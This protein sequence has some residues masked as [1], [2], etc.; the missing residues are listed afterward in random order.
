MKGKRIAITI[1]IFFLVATMLP[2]TTFAQ[3]EVPYGP[4][5]DTITMQGEPEESKVVDMLKNND[6]DVHL[7]DIADPDLLP[8]IQAAPNLKYSTVLG[9]YYDLTLNPAVF[10]TAGFNPFS[11][12]KVREAMN[13]L[14]D[15]NYIVDEISKGLAVP[16]WVPTSNGIPDYGRLAPTIKV[17]EAK[18]SYDFEKAR[19][20]FTTELEKMGAKFIGGRWYYNDE[21]IEIKF[22]IRNDDIQRW[23]IGDY[24]ANQMEKL[25]FQTDRRYGKSAELSPIWA[26][27]I[28]STGQFHIYT[29]GWIATA[30]DRDAGDDFA[31]FYTK[32]SLMAIYGYTLW[33]YKENDPE[34]YD[35]AD[36]L[37][38]GDWTSWEE[39]NQLWRRALVL[40]MEDSNHVWLVNTA[41]P[42]PMNEN[43][44]VATDLLAGFSNDLWARTIRWEDQIG[45][46]VTA[47]DREV[48]NDPWNPIGL[49]NYAYDQIVI[50]CTNDYEN[51]FN[52]YTGLAVPNRFV[53]VT[54]EV[55]DAFEGLMVD[56]SEWLDLQF[57]ESVEV[58][59]DAWY[60]WNVETKEVITAPPGTYAKV[61]IVV[62]YGDVIGNVKYHDG[63]VMSLADWLAFWPLRFERANPQS[64]VYDESYASAYQTF[65]TNFRGQRLVTESPLVIEYY[66]NVTAL[67]AEDVLTSGEGARALPYIGTYGYN[68]WPDY[69]WHM[70]A[71]GMD[72]EEQNIGVTWT[73]AKA[74]KVNGEWMSYIAGE[75]LAVLKNALDTSKADNYR[76]LLASEYASAEEAT[77]RYA[78]LESWYNDKGHFWVASG[79]F[80]LDQADFIAHI[81]VVKAFR[82]Y[83]FKADRWA[84]LTSPPIPE[85]SV[86]LP[87]IVAGLPGS[88]VPGVSASF[89]LKLSSAGQPYPN[90]RIDFVKY[91]VVDSAGGVIVDGDATAG[92]EGEWTITLGSAATTNMMEGTYN[93][94]TIALSK[95]VA[96]PGMLETAFQVSLGGVLSYFEARL[97]QQLQVQQSELNAAISELESTLGE[98]NSQLQGAI[99]SMQ[100]IVYAAIAIAAVAVVIAIYAVAKKA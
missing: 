25:G 95:D 55:D 65:R 93:L 67:E 88:I 18:Y 86:E 73:K 15:R 46:T 76:P 97:Q 27:P 20:I 77:E 28:P 1:L 83:Q 70:V 50:S 21:W 40:C 81:A 31:F 32:L 60:E 96:L 8:A 68:G 34:F 72:V 2:I 64:T 42:F 98:Q 23:Q 75:S 56:S 24:V 53:N 47:S 87:E 84:W 63:S 74:T 48:L 38:R 99:G 94:L 22:L 5:V 43:L 37:N 80:Y 69:P 35:I 90:D 26:Q 85:S 7:I 51:L 29:G 52:P 10:E 92:A 82:D 54:M 30:I 57:I 71:I 78:N 91:L 36:R 58:P 19:E 44:Q 61:K 39:R 4:W 17:L 62:N 79:P 11:N 100:T 3:E 89:T 49:T 41:P 66:T 13:H 16:K 45:G 33:E 6:V 9:L 14:I 12:P 59:T